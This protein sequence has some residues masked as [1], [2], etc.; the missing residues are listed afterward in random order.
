MLLKQLHLNMRKQVG[1][2]LQSQF[3]YKTLMYSSVIL[4]HCTNFNCQCQIGAKCSKK[5]Q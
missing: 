1:G 4:L 3:N 5:S 2:I